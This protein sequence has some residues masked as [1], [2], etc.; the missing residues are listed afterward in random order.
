MFS[1]VNVEIE[2]GGDFMCIISTLT[3]NSYVE[4]M[5]N[6]D[7]T[8]QHNI[9]A[10]V[11]KLFNDKLKSVSGSNIQYIIQDGRLRLVTDTAKEDILEINDIVTFEVTTTGLRII[12]RQPFK[13]FVLTYNQICCI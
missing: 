13:V 9:L 7:K 12:C 8:F 3:E 10:V 5:K 2:M 11:L 4:K 1:C 6:C